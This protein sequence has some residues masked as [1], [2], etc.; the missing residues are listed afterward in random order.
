MADERLFTY[1][2]LVE[3][4]FCGH[5]TDKEESRKTARNIWQW[6]QAEIH[7]TK[8]KTDNDTNNRVNV[9]DHLDEAFNNGEEMRPLTIAKRSV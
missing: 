1:E 7:D 5:I 8:Q 2:R 9:L 3:I 6:L 4:A